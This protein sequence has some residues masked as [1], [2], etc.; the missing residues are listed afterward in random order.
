[1]ELYYWFIQNKALFISV[2][3]SFGAVCENVSV[4]D[5]IGKEI[6]VCSF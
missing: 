1:M 3:G 6:E 4:W 5:A 2:G